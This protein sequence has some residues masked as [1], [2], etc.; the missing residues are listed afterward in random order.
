MGGTRRKAPRA[1]PIEARKHGTERPRVRE[2]IDAPPR[3]SPLS[4]NVR[5]ERAARACGLVDVMRLISGVRHGLETRVTI[6]RDGRPERVPHA[7]AAT[8][9]GASAPT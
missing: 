7:L 4:G 3:G 9:V 2:F 8:G 5:R 6:E 1:S